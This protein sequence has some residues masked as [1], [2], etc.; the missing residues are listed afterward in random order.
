[1]F[2]DTKKSHIASKS[3]LMIVYKKI[4]EGNFTKDKTVRTH[5]RPK[6]DNTSKNE[7]LWTC[8]RNKPKS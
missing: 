5:T 3:R 4:Q 7:V 6:T 1:M 2:Q 8:D